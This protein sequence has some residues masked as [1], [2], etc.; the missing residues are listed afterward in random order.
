MIELDSI[1]VMLMVEALVALVLLVIVFFIFSRG[2]RAKG[3]SAVNELINKFEDT[4]NIKA[5]KLKSLISDNCTVEADL[6]Q[7]LIKEMNESEKVLYQKI[8][9]LFLN[10]D[11]E[12]LK[13]IDE[14]I[15]NLSE[16]YCKLLI[17]SSSSPIES[18]KMDAIDDKVNRLSKENG[19]LSEQLSVA[20]NTMDEISAEYTRVYSGSQTEL[21]LENSSKKMFKTFSEAEQNIKQLY[22]DAEAEEL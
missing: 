19:R 3:Q 18:G 11:V 14:H 4:E 1:V 22:K 12:L 9:Q 7:A 8:V 15:D 2:K 21:E 10:R 6:L 16:P 17:H 5:K 20:M 13:D